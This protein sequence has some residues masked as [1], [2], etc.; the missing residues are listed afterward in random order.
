MRGKDELAAR[1]ERGSGR[2][3]VQSDRHIG[4]FADEWIGAAAGLPDDEPGRQHNAVGYGLC[5]ESRKEHLGGPVRHLEAAK[6]RSSQGRG[7]KAPLR[8]VVEARYGDV[9]R[10]TQ[11]PAL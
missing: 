5:L 4:S 11:T 7:D 2:A 1:L 6:G 8:F 3:S 9:G 10:D